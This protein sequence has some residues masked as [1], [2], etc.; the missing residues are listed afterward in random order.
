VRPVR[1]RPW[2]VLALAVALAVAALSGCNLDASAAI[3]RLPPA[4]DDGIN[5][6]QVPFGAPPAVVA[7]ESAV[8]GASGRTDPEVAPLAVA[9]RV[10]NQPGRRT[11]WIILFDQAGAWV[12][13]GGPPDG[14]LGPGFPRRMCSLTHAGPIID[15]Q[16]GEQIYWVTLGW[17]VDHPGAVVQVRE[18]DG[19]MAWF[20]VFSTTSEAYGTDQ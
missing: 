12:P 15:D 10:L 16:T 8:S 5:V 2:A 7:M 20:R 14:S 4:V 18:L 9:R 6:L 13:C 17:H 1:R 11:V 3:G 19:Q